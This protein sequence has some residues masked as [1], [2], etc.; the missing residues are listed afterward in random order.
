MVEFQPSKLAVRVRFPS[1]APIQGYSS[2]GRVLVSKTMGRGFESFCPCQNKKPPS[3][4]FLFWRRYVGSSTR[5]ASRREASGLASRDLVGHRVLLPLPKR[6]PSLLRWTSFSSAVYW[7]EPHKCAAF[8]RT[9]AS[10]T[11]AVRSCTR[12]CLGSESFCRTHHSR[13]RYT[14]FRR[15]RNFIVI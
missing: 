7:L 6:S 13:G 11:A 2:V 1:P 10:G 12:V 14:C 4:V 5:V 15:K 9:H 8:V 3:A